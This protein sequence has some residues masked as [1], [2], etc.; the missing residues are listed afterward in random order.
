MSGKDMFCEDMP[1]EDLSN[2]SLQTTIIFRKVGSD[3]MER[4]FRKDLSNALSDA[5]CLFFTFLYL[6]FFTSLLCISNFFIGAKWFP[7]KICSGKT[8]PMLSCSNSYSFKSE[9]LFHGKTCLGKTCPTVLGS[10]LFF[11]KVISWKDFSVKDP[12]NSASKH[13]ISFPK[14]EVI[15]RKDLSR[16]DLFN[17]ALQQLLFLEGGRWFPGNP[18]PKKT[19]VIVLQSISCFFK[20]EKTFPGKPHPI[21]PE[22]EHLTTISALTA[23]SI[24]SCD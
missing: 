24:L 18:C 20:G 5:F 22:P 2:F 13:L 6:H 11:F 14:R 10:I 17:V 9:K 23:V 7:E 19:R 4:L 3:F 16:V 21:L 12:F 8:C 1:R 15:S